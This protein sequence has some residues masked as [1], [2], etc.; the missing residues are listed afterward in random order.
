MTNNRFHLRKSTL[1]NP[2]PRLS[3]PR[4]PLTKIYARGCDVRNEVAV[5]L[6]LRGLLFV[7]SFREQPLQEKLGNHKEI[8]RVGVGLDELDRVGWVFS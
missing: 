5:K 4:K 6:Q 8:K 2:T 3:W 7:L 1:S